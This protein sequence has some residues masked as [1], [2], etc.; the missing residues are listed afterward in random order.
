MYV[1]LGFWETCFKFFSV[2]KK[3]L[4]PII[5]CPVFHA[6]QEHLSTILKNEKHYVYSMEEFWKYRLDIFPALK[7]F[8]V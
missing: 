7:N 1:F 8:I 4:S 2:T 5:S 3:A 6:R